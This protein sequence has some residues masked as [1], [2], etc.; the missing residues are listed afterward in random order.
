MIVEHKDGYFKV[1]PCDACQNP[2]ISLSYKLRHE[3]N[4]TCNCPRCNGNGFITTF[5]NI[6][7]K[8]EKPA[9]IYTPE[10][11]AEAKRLF[12]VEL[13]TIVEIAKK[14][15]VAPSTITTWLGEYSPA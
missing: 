12:E 13:Y 5:P 4:G 3:K 6:V 15:G 7:K 8:F 11:G 2:N 14:F 10:I 9:K 1:I